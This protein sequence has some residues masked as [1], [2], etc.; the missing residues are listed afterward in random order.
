MEYIS[1]ER[2]GV[3]FVHHAVTAERVQASL[4]EMAGDAVDV[5]PMPAGP[6]NIATVKADGRIG[7]IK[8]DPDPGDLI[9][10]VAVLPIEL[11][12]EVKIGPVSNRFSGTVEVPLVMQA[13]TATP[14]LIVIDI[15]PITPSDVRVTLRSQTVGGDVLQRVGNMEAEV[16]SQVARTVNARLISKEAEK[17]RVIDVAAQI[18]ESWD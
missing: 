2:F 6:G 17:N 1:Y 14:L 16:Q 11:D 9:R 7:K 10:F 8:V 4:T 15:S 12:L 13:R 5:G 18:E 3:N